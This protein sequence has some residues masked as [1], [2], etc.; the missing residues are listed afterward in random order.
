MPHL[1]LL[2]Q[3]RFDLVAQAAKFAADC[4]AAAQAG[5]LSAPPTGSVYRALQPA[6]G[7]VGLLLQF[8]AVNSATNALS[9]AAVRTRK[10]QVLGLRVCNV[11]ALLRHQDF[12]FTVAIVP[13]RA[14]EE[15]GCIDGVLKTMWTEFEILSDGTPSHA[16]W[17]CRCRSDA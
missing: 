16:H 6:P 10:F 1:M 15:V 9:R 12:V 13:P 4:E 17:E 3:R 8:D 5:V 2:L 14:Y 11:P 7:A